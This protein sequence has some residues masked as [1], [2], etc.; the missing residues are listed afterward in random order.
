LALHRETVHEKQSNQMS[1]LHAVLQV[2]Y[3]SH[4]YFR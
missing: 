2:N 3:Y 4:L 1:D